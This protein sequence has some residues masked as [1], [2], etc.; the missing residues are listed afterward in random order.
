MNNKV[1][2]IIGMG[3]GISYSVAERF[4]REGYAVA[5]FARNEARLSLFQELL[6]RQL[7]VSRYYPVDAGN[8]KALQQ[9]LDKMCQEM[10][11]PQVLVYNASKNKQ[12]HI[13][14]E[15]AESISDDLLINVGGALEAVQAL[16][17]AMKAR[18]AGTILL[19]GGGLALHPNPAM[20]A[21]SIG[22]S[23]LR[24]LA[25]QLHNALA[26]DGIK[27]ATITVAGFVTKES[28]THHPDRIADLYW[29]IHQTPVDQVQAEYLV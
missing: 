17:P 20:G 24:S 14:D 5:M 27:V 22:K 12:L 2:A 11:Y 26:P 28:T 7:V 16:L 18:Q 15:T 13:L 3:Q 9:A 4:A 1:I 25:I 19:T 21:L 23:G 8:A 6:E 10:G 29:D